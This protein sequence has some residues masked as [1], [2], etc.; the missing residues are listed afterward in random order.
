MARSRHVARSAGASLLP[1]AERLRV[2][3]PVARGFPQGRVPR[4]PLLGAERPCPSRRRGRPIGRA[5]SWAAGAGRAL[6]QGR[7]PGAAAEGDRMG[8]SLSCA[9][10][11]HAHRG[12]PRLRLRPAELQKTS[13][14]GAGDRPAELG[15][16]VR[17]MAAS[18]RGARRG[19]PRR[20]A[21]DLARE[22]RLA[23]R[24][25]RP[26]GSRT[27][28][29][30]ARSSKTGDRATDGRTPDDRTIGERGTYGRTLTLRPTTVGTAVAGPRVRA[31]APDSRGS[32][33]TRT[34]AP[35]DTVEHRG[36]HGTFATIASGAYWR[37]PEAY[38]DPEVR[39]SISSLAT[40]A[41]PRGLERLAAD[42]SRARGRGSTATSCARPSWISDTGS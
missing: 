42:R 8:E 22:T 34:L 1:F 7:Q 36:G 41:S 31:S 25:R 5:R 13:G 40:G 2:L 16:V 39:A 26:R 10:A 15:A 30:P 33:G 9:R 19:E 18:H 38:L 20:V 3:A 35:G 6:R 11:A 14:R 23:P 21:Q 27:A 37:R 12:A 17:W 32:S 29:R 4:R 24:G 28:E